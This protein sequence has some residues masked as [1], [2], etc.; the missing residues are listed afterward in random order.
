MGIQQQKVE[1]GD[2]AEVIFDFVDVALVRT[3]VDPE[4]D[5]LLDSLRCGRLKVSDIVDMRWDDHLLALAAVQG[6]AAALRLAP[7]RLRHDR[8]FV[9]TAVQARATVLR[10][11]GEELRSDYDIV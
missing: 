7:A 5:E 4:R 6:D 8:N 3:T 11:A 10:Y 2:D 1:P 9:L